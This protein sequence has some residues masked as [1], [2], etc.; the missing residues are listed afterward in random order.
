MKLRVLTCCS[1][2]LAFFALGAPAWA[3]KVQVCHVPPGNPSNFHTI[4]ISE[5]ALQAHL[6]HGDLPGTCFAHCDTL[7]SDGNPCTIDACD[8]SEQCLVTHP[9]VNCDDGNLCTNDSC[10]PESGCVSAP[11]TCLDSDLCSVDSC[12]P[13]TGNCVFPA[14]VCPTGQ[15][16]NAGTGS[17][18]NQAPA[19]P[20]QTNPAF[21]AVLAGTALAC[22][23]GP[24][25]V[26]LQSSNFTT[27]YAT[28]SPLPSLCG[29]SGMPE[30]SITPQQAQACI[31]LIRTYCPGG[32]AD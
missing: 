13:L 24:N 21:N 14:V 15:T 2:L 31:A 16:C 23:G 19:C 29:A 17:C 4:T 27:A 20:C 1:L 11:K 8:A 28:T 3:A 6:A 18:E 10:N 32:Q 9:P 12:D 26:T 30:Q 7:C 25:S 22:F 5:N